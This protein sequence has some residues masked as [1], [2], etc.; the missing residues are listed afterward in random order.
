[1]EYLLRYIPN[2]YKIKRQYLDKNS[3]KIEVLFLG[4]SHAYYGIN[5]KYI[6]FISFNAAYVSQSLDYDYEIIKKYENSWDNLRFIVI[7]ID[8]S[9]LFTNLSFSVESW[10]IKN[11]EIYFGLSKSII[12]LNKF[13]VLSVKTRHNLSRLKSYF[14]NHNMPKITTSPLGYGN[15]NYTKKDLEITGNMAAKRHTKSDFSLLQY[16]KDIFLEII[17]LAEKRNIYILLYTSPSYKSYV[18][19]LNEKQLEVQMNTIHEF[20][21]SY[22]NISYYDFMND[23]AFGE[24]EFRDAD[25]LNHI[26]A[27][28]L[29]IKINSILNDLRAN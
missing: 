22:E 17:K 16:N 20:L 29:S 27:Q 21:Q 26:G 24:N 1:M 12:P 23:T 25:H 11:Y 3:S 15:I 13:E 8:Y 4:N 6:D 19:K 18:S 7:P 10:R 9:T 28:L 14:I 2:D 5:P